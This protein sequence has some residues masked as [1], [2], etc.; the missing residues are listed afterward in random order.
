MLFAI[1]CHNFERRLCWQLS[2]IMQQRCSIPRIR[3]AV[4][5][6]EDGYTLD[7]VRSFRARGMDIF[8]MLYFDRNRFARRGYV[9]NDQV[10][11]AREHG[12]EWIFFADCDNVYHPDFFA[13]LF[14]ALAPISP[15]EPQCIFSTSKLH[16]SVAE[17]NAL[18]AKHSE[19]VIPDA[20]AQALA[21]PVIHKKNRPV[22]AGCM[23]VCGV[24]AIVKKTGGLYV[25]GRSRDKHLFRERQGARSDIQ[26]RRS[27]G[28]G[29]RVDLPPQIHLNHVRDKEAGRHLE[30]KR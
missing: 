5:T 27:F 29:L 4:A 22:A 1:Q 16:T 25:T 11:R 24:D 2:S 20:F 9:R 23:Q 17:T 14:S 13:Q 21:L 15:M 28:R 6:T 7:V 18:L 12:S 8:P 30:E 19:Y 26:F 3:V 10:A